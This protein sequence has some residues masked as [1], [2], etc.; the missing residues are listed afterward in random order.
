MRL[1][2]QREYRQLIY[3]GDGVVGNTVRLPR[4]PRPCLSYRFEMS[5][6]SPARLFDYEHA[7]DGRKNYP[8]DD[9]FETQQRTDEALEA[10]P[11]YYAVP[12]LPHRS[13]DP[14]DDLP[15]N[16]EEVMES[17]LEEA[18]NV[19]AECPYHLIINL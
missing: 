2:K 3:S 8:N 9:D 4:F 11:D 17:R 10:F 18:P 15:T 7:E 12:E 16:P 19:N 1:R 6:R 14:N 13:E 5:R